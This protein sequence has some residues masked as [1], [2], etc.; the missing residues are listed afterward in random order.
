MERPEQGDGG[1]LHTIVVFQPMRVSEEP[2]FNFSLSAK[3]S[4]YL[5]AFDISR[6]S[7][8]VSVVLKNAAK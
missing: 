5:P 7:R 6:S 2:V 4:F 8:T 1:A 3:S